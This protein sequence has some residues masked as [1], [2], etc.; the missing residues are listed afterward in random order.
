[1]IGETHTPVLVTEVI[2]ALAIR[3]DGRYID[4]T[5]GR[6]GHSSEIVDRLAS[7]GRLCV[8]DRDDQAIAVAKERFGTDPRVTIVKGRFSMLRHYQENVGW[9]GSV[10]GILF[11]LGV[12]SPQIDEASRGFSF[13]YDGPLDM[14]MDTQSDLTAAR[15]L[16]EAEEDEIAAVL[17]DFGEERY[18]K[19]IARAIVLARATAPLTTT[20]DLATLVAHQIPHREPHQD[21]ATRT[22]Q[23]IR[24][25]I[26]DELTEITSALPEACT[27]LRPGG[28]LAVISFHSLE[29]RIV[30]RFFQTQARGDPYPERFPV[31]HSALRPRLKLLGKAVRATS[32]EVER[33]PRSRSAV[34]RVAECL[35]AHL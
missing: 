34:L 30:K 24:V 18:A 5:F 4:A 22:F 6:G 3:P 9:Q 19:R 16:A 31:R 35:E 11:D 33:N 23:A 25:R 2:E 17:R 15:W 10:D 21:P 12:S 14:R 8:I 1:M 26:N 27:L 20:K 29:D 32:A 7:Q 28:R 13:R